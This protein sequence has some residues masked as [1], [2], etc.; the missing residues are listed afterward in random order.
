MSN[1]NHYN[2][3]RWQVN[4]GLHK[5]NI[6]DNA[7]NVRNSEL[8][9]KEAQVKLQAAVQKHVK[10]IDSSSEEEDLESDNVIGKLFIL[11][12][13]IFTISII[14]LDG[15]LKNYGGKELLGRTEGYLHEAFVSNASICLICISTVRR[16]D[17][18]SNLF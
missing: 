13:S 3:N 7:S 5:K 6:K 11:S 14:I 4:N 15:I 16:V 17:S 8:K 1:Q 9:F 18:V 12:L 10:A 2:K